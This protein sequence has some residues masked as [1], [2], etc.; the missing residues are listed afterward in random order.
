MTRRGNLSPKLPR[1]AKATPLK[2][3]LPKPASWMRK[4]QSM[5]RL[6]RPGFMRGL[7][8]TAAKSKESGTGVAAAS[9]FR[10]TGG[11]RS[12]GSLGGSSGR[13]TG[14]ASRPRMSGGVARGGRP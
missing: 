11:M 7:R 6:H 4:L 5:L 8:G 10:G 12:G 3:N 9:P 13:V 2:A 14:R 1:I